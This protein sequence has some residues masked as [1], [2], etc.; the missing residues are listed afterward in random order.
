MSEKSCR[1]I[2][3]SENVIKFFGTSHVNQLGGF[4]T[5]SLGWKWHDIWITLWPTTW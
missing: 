3:L 4:F 1:K 5:F 2:T